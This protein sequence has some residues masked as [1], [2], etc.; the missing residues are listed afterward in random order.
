MVVTG[1]AAAAPLSPPHPRRVAIVAL[2]TSPP[3]SS[4]AWRKHSTTG[5]VRFLPSNLSLPP[6]LITRSGRED[7]RTGAAARLP[8]SLH[9]WAR[10]CGRSPPFLHHR[11]RSITRAAGLAVCCCGV[12]GASGRC[13][14][15]RR[16]QLKPL[17]SWV[18]IV[19]SC[20]AVH[21]RRNWARFTARTDAQVPDSILLLHHSVSYSYS[22]SFGNRMVGIKSVSVVKVNGTV[23]AAATE[24]EPIEKEF[25]WRS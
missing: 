2:T 6:R 16:P 19:V 8:S 25:M 22:S 18:L 17:A 15:R 1:L 23:N 11:R 21:R 14:G 13:A 9:G 12:A 20:S 5:F 10:R 4:R 7:A 3:S 24:C